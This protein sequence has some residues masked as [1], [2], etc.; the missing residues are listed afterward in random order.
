MFA[1]CFSCSEIEHGVPTPED[2][3]PAEVTNVNAVGIPG[4]A[5]IT[6]TLPQNNNVLY[7]AAE[8]DIGDGVLRDKKASIYGTG[9]TVE[10][11]PDTRER[12]ITLYS[13]SHSGHKSSPKTVKI[14][15]DTPPYLAAYNSMQIEP[16]FGGAKIT[17]LNESK[18]DLKI[19]AQTTDSIGE[20]YTAYT[21]Y[22][23]APEGKFSIRG[24]NTDE[25][26]FACYTIDRWN[27]QS[28]VLEE[29]ITPWFETQLDRKKFLA[30][31]LPT[32][33]WQYHMSSSYAIEMAWDGVYGT[34][35]GFHTI[36]NSG[37]PQWFALDLGVTARLSRMK[38]WSRLA[39][40]SGAGSDGQYSNGDPKRLEIWGS[41]APNLDGS[42][43]ES[44]F[45]LGS[46]EATKPSGDARWTDEDI[47]YACYDGQDFE[48]TDNTPVRYLRV[49]VTE[50]WGGVTYMYIGELAFWGEEIPTDDEP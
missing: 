21:H 47:Q 20:F 1:A 29:T 31:K 30:L 44:W 23:K 2:I 39:G 22:T 24:F 37:I 41:N 43:D 36:P 9:L 33:T 42:W 50:V 16:T 38:M 49:K 45:L 35:Y 6:Y 48:F 14:T 46:F 11:F 28:A 27:N 40:S 10:G 12:S 15:P 3:V 8:Y 34:T 26:R 32:D 19:I 18:A 17:F 25:R 13:V 5:Y 7:V 4:G